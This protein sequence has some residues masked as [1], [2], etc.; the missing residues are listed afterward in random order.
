M[1]ESGE[2]IV[3][4][5]DFLKKQAREDPDFLKKIIFNQNGQEFEKY[6]ELLEKFKSYHPKVKAKKCDITT[7]EKGNLLEYL[8]Q[9]LLIQSGLYKIKTNIKNDS[10]EIDVITEYNDLGNIVKDIFPAFL[11]QNFLC[12]CKNYSGNIDVTWVGKFYS[13]L[14]TTDKKLGIIFS[15]GKI[16]GKNE[17][18][19]AK[20]LI[21]KLYLKEEIII[22]NFNIDDFDSIVNGEILPVILQR[23]YDKLV[24][25]TDFSKDISVHPAEIFYKNIILK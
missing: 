25:L 6:K 9:F 4:M 16:T 10:N 1:C 18:D 5:V 20:A 3:Y 21:K 11:K 22:L 7:T 23:E 24:Y 2:D 12:E 15:Y 8:V 17:W 19:A 14:K 13:L